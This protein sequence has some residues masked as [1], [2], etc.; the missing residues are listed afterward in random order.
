MYVCM[1]VYNCIHVV[2][3]V[4][5]TLVTK[6]YIKC[7]VNTIHIDFTIS[8]KIMNLIHTV[9]VWDLEVFC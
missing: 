4:F 8:E 1:Y 5:K 7:T 3:A 2:Y 6:P 9:Q